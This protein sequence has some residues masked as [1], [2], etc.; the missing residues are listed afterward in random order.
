MIKKVYPKNLEK[1]FEES[2]KRLK[3]LR[4]IYVPVIE[5]LI[6]TSLRGVDS[7]GIRLFPHYVKEV[8]SGRINKNP[9][10]RFKKK[11]RSVGF[12][13]ADNT[14]GI[15]ASVVAMNKAISLAKKT[16]VGF[17]AVKN[18]SHFGA[19][20][21]YSLIA[22]KKDMI[23]LCGTH[24]ESLVV[25]PKGKLPFLG[26]NPIAFAAPCEGEEP[27][28]LDMSTSTVSFNKIR[29]H[30]ERAESLEGGWA[31]DQ[32]GNSCIDPKK[33]IYLTPFGGYK[34]FGIATMIEI[35]C[36]ILT[37]M[38]FGPKITPMFSKLNKKR[39]LGHF[40]IAI[41]ISKFQEISIFKKRLK[42]MIFLLRE[43][44]SS[45]DSGKTIVAN[46]L[47]KEIFKMRIKK[48][49]PLSKVD[50]EKF[51]EIS[52]LLKVNKNLLENY[53]N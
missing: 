27:Y 2:F 14:F 20:G 32:E 31:V 6:N 38:N 5:G 34:G 30:K 37:G 44:P 36:S 3:I 26:T 9:K 21:I 13:D 10:F 49:I 11:S 1:F 35:L 15:T 41:D 40:F 8:L 25:P 7:H 51:E 47:E 18:S 28:C 4:R 53:K 42:E 46:D 12:I 29:Q 33:E 24:T 16:G 17:V 45:R 23:G 50:L 39:G 19:A 43:I 52:K 48:G 22:A